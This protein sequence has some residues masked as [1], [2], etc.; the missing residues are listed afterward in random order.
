M[1]TTLRPAMLADAKPIARILDQLG[2]FE[3]FSAQDPKLQED[4]VK[5]FLRE[6]LDSP[7]QECQVAVNEAGRV[8]GYAHC[9]QVPYF[10]LPEAEWYLSELFVESEH[11]RQGVGS[12]LLD[13][14]KERAVARGASR[15]SLFTGRHRDSFQ[16]G[17]YTKR[18]FIDKTDRASMICPM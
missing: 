5:S 16:S 17:F 9:H 2:W 10:F 8:V 3:E 15:V 4:R 11:Q 6:T 1:K 12:L 13:W 18:G 14:V 7:T